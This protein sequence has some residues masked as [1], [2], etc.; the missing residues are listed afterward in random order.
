MAKQTEFVVIG[1]G[2]AG[3][4]A[5]CLLTEAG[6]STTVLE[7]NWLPGGCASS[8][9]RKHYI[10]E[11]GATTLVGLEPGMP[12]QY[13]VDQLGIDIPAIQLEIPMKVYLPNGNILTRY[14]DLDQWIAEAERVFGPEGQRPFWEYCYKVSQFVW[15]TSIKQR[16]F[17]PTS[18]R[19]LLPTIKHFQPRQL[20]FA[21]LALK[22][23]KQLLK[24]YGL[25]Q[26]S[27]FVSFINEQLLITAQNHID[28]EMYSLALQLCV[29][30]NTL[31][32]MCR[33]D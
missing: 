18:W 23:M 28:E 19:D 5:A 2:I 32:T 21:P 1:G 30:L 24:D 29:I 10:F 25:D 13:V 22:S 14:Q 16:T 8:Y 15:D 3:L 9:P 31:I 17:P 27:A 12:L 26:H 20:A 4:T 11:S 6:F 33:E 7:Q